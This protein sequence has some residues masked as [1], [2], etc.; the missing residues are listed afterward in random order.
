MRPIPRKKHLAGLV[1]AALVMAGFV[2]VALAFGPHRV[3]PDAGSTAVGQPEPASLAFSNGP[4]LNGDGRPDSVH[5]TGDTFTV[6]AGGGGDLLRFEAPGTPDYR[7]ARLGGEYPVL[8]VATARGEYAA[9]AYAPGKGTLEA[10]TWPDGRTRGYGELTADGAL[11][12]AVV[13][14]GM[15]TRIARMQLNQLHLEPVETVWRPLTEARQTPSDALAA[16]VEAAALGLKDEMAVHFPDQAVAAAF[17][18]KWHGTLPPGRALVALADQVDG[19]A[20]HG[21]LVPVT[22]WV[23]G[24]TGVAGLRGAAE[25]ASG[26]AGV[27]I[28]RAD[29]APVPLKVRS[30]AEAQA[31]LKAARPAAPAAGLQRAQVPF[32]GQF[33]FVAGDHRYAVG[34]ASGEVEDE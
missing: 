4:D 12:Q 1:T 18:Q 10:V 3:Q 25:F 30:W 34:A 28:M 17:Y 24:E 23:A 32:Y 16:A 29:L 19:G 13:G 7:V 8:F 27:Q 11:S 33:R 2:A 6:T 15:R 22:V 5:F 9:F 14:S 21:H 31:K 26:P 20:E